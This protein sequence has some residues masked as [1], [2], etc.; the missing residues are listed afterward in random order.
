MIYSDI[1]D[2][3]GLLG[4]DHSTHELY[5]VSK[6]RYVIKSISPS[7]GDWQYIKKSEWDE[8]SGKASMVRMMPL[9]FVAVQD[10]VSEETLTTFAD[11]NSDQWKGNRNF[12][13]ERSGKQ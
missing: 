9:P 3:L 7:G 8:V 5:A 4:V 1:P 13:I 11:S 10:G 12:T 2:I 6:D